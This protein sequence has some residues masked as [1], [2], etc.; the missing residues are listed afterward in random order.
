MLTLP[1]CENLRVMST[2]DYAVALPA[3]PLRAYVSH[4][5]GSRMRDLPRGQHAGLP[6]R[7]ID[8]IVS[9]AKPIE[10]ARMPAQLAGPLY[11][12]GSSAPAEIATR[13]GA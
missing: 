1:V 6:S 8:L 11:R 7:Y 4:Y 13:H 2:G 10:I 12:S 9:L 3:L 5:A